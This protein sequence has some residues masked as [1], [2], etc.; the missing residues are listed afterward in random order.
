MADLLSGGRG[1]V[2]KF[3]KR[4]GIF[5]A[6]KF[7]AQLDAVKNFGRGRRMSNAGR[8]RRRPAVGSRRER[9]GERLGGYCRLP[10][11]AGAHFEF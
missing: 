4:A 9:V 8:R 10:E 7:V 3:S 1:I 11:V 5:L 6:P 2:P